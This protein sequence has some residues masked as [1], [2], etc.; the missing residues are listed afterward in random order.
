MTTDRERLDLLGTSMWGERRLLRGGERGATSV[1]FAVLL[2]VLALALI[3][4]VAAYGLQLGPVF[5]TAATDVELV[6]NGSAPGG[7]EPGGAP[8][9]QVPGGPG[10]S[11]H[12]PGNGNPPHCPP[13]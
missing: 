11:C 8:G 5:A 12:N 7:Q 10:N 6:G 2:T 13:P 3:T 9:G 4:G 1:E